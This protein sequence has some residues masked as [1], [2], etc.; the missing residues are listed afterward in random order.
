MNL[1]SAQRAICSC[2]KGK[3]APKW[4]ATENK[5]KNIIFFFGGLI[6]IDQLIQSS[7][8]IVNEMALVLVVLCS[9]IYFDSIRLPIYVA[10]YAKLLTRC[11]AI[12][13]N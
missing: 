4:P 12:K 13:D 5:K 10:P 7:A 9:S 2:Q 8:P 11:I 1:L 6:S 3:A